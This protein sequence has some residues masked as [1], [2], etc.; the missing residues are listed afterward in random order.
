MRVRKVR[1]GFTL[2]EL[3]VVIAIIG[4]LVGLLLPAVQAAREAARRMQCTNN[5][6][7]LGLALHNYES[8]YKSLPS[9]FTTNYPASSWGT[10]AMQAVSQ[11]SHWSWGAFILP[12]IE[13]QS[14][15]TTVNPNN[16]EMFQVL[17]T[18]VG[19]AAL[20]TPLPTFACPSDPGP[21][22]NNFDATQS[23]APANAA[24]PWYNRFVTS[25][26]TDRIAIA[27]SNY[28]MSACSSVSTTPP[29]AEAVFG[30]ATGVA[31]LNSRCRLAQI[32]DGTSHT[33]AIGER[34]YRFAN[35]NAGAGNA[36]GFSSTVNTPG[37]SAGLKAAMTA[38]LGLAYNG[39]NW[40]ANNRIH[41]PRG[42]SSNHANGAN[43]VFCD[44]SVQFL[45]NSID[46]NG[47]TIPSGTLT[48]GA[49]IDSVFE[50]LIG[51]SDG[52]VTGWVA[53]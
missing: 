12:Y 46:Y 26:G 41:Q 42:Y 16:L 33:I 17:A 22:L 9:G 47:V 51:K 11:Q 24:A 18:P 8:V 6:K 1:N 23:D 37:T 40:S 15:Y 21:P 19:L 29:V 45:S 3:L 49:W 44:G 34:A 10:P 4:I 35:L 38:V 39:I 20:T 13:Q 36:L 52:Q 48:N 50:R 30:P 28:I 5:L 31:W 53:E 25:N 32:T 27:K 43:F 2:V 7:Q 14:L